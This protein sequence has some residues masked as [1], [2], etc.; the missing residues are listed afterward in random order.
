MI[1]ELLTRA[2]DWTWIILGLILLGLE[3]LAPGT[4]FMWLGLAALGVG[5]IALLVDLAW[6][7]EVLLFGVFALAF[8]FAGRQFFARSG[9]ESTDTPGLNERGKMHLG[10][11]LT[12]EEPLVGGTGRVKLGDTMWRIEGP[13]LPAGARVRVTDVRGATLLVDAL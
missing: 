8:I 13:D 11:E 7:L 1:I 3:L 2:G 10:R 9:D 12:L 6:Q 5:V 4:F